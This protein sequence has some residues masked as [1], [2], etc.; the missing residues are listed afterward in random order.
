MA[1]PMA[2]FTLVGHQSL[3]LITSL[4]A[5]TALYGSTL[6]LGDR[7][8]ALP[9]VGAGFVVAS[10]LGVLCA[11]NAWLTI[12]CFV[13]VATLASILVLGTELG[14]PGPMQFVLVAG[15]SGQLATSARLGDSSLDALAI[16]ALVAVGALSASVLAVALFALALVRQREGEPGWGKLVPLAWLEGKRALIATRVVVAV[17]ISGLVSLILGVHRY[18]WVVMVAGAVLQASH[19]LLATANRTMHRVLGTVLGVAVFGLI[20]LVEPS[21]LWLVGVLALLQFAI[22]VVVARHYALALTFITPT[23]LTIAAAGGTSDR[24]AIVRERTVD[25]V[26]GA[27]IALLVLWTSEWVGARHAKSR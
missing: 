4:G 26:V 23:A 5:F 18:Y 15:V 3:G 27:V 21:G 2:A 7:L 25:T 19:G 8:R 11:G 16:P 14:P 12:A 10:A 6:R 13:A 17:A 9:L 1:L 20:Q 22:E 24:L